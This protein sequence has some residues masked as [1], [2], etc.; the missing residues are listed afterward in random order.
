MGLSPKSPTRNSRKERSPRDPISGRRATLSLG[1]APPMDEGSAR[2]Q[3]LVA[4]SVPNPDMGAHPPFKNCPRERQLREEEGRL[5]TQ[6][7]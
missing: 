2:R 3:V 1:P 6:G 5:E 4:A 7:Q